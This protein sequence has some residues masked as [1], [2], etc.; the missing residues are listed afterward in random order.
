ML[1]KSVNL[2]LGLGNHR[3]FRVFIGHRRSENP[4]TTQNSPANGHLPM[5]IFSSD[6]EKKYS[7]AT[8]HLSP[9]TRILNENPV[10]LFLNHLIFHSAG[11]CK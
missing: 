4:F 5:T 8:L 10:T 11:N 7:P 9:A 6:V 2:L 1:S 3:Y